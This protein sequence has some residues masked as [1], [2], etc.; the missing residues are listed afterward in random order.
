MDKS[1]T[2][3]ELRFDILAMSKDLLDR[4]YETNREIA[5]RAFELAGA[6]ASIGKI[7]DRNT[8]QAMSAWDKYVPK[9]YTPE[10]IK[11]NAEMLYEFVTK[12]DH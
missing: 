5:F 1:K 12:K 6:M 2:P 10:E 3:F 11:K 4:T 8:E 9:M 7:E